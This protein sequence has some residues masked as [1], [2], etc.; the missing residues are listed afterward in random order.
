MQ[1]S[2]IQWISAQWVTSACLVLMVSIKKDYS[3]FL[4]QILTLLLEVLAGKVEYA[5]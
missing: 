4:S 2:H 1:L 3:V 5:V